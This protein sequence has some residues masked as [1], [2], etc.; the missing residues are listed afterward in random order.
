[1]SATHD[2]R[3]AEELRKGQEERLNKVWETPKGWRYWSGV[4][5]TEVGVWYTAT[6]FAFMLF[7]GV[8]GLLARVQ[9]AGS[10]AQG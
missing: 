2:G 9:L 8:L 10:A 1:M 5:N 7:A 6:S 3:D 4:N